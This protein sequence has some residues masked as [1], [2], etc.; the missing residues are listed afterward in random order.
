MLQNS[1]IVWY[2]R[3]P[4]SLYSPGASGAV[5]VMNS[6]DLI[7]AADR[8]GWTASLLRCSLCRVLADYSLELDGHMNGCHGLVTCQIPSVARSLGPQNCEISCRSHECRR[9][10]RL[11]TVWGAHYSAALT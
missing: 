9:C 4:N 10:K 1:Y 8:L 2:A 3:V 11:V 6:G 5:E 7:G